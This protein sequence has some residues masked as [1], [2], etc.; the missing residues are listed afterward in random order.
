MILGDGCMY[1]VSREAYIKFKQGYKQE[2]FI[3]NLFIIFNTYTFMEKPG[4]RVYL[5]GLDK[6][7]TKSFWFKTFSHQ[8]FTTL[9]NLFYEEKIY[10]NKII[11]KKKISK[12]LILDYLTPQGLAYWIMCDGSLQ[13]DK[14]TI[15][16][17]TQGFNLKENS[18]LSS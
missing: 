3:D 2:M 16:L 7:K 1:K 18:I 12:N 15:I 10:N 5:S 9:F 13:N 14:K 4:K 11:K 6:R 17:H 8:I